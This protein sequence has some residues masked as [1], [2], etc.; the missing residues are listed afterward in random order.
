MN[1]CLKAGDRERPLDADTQERVSL[2]LTLLSVIPA[3]NPRRS[4]LQSLRNLAIWTG[5]PYGAAAAG[6][7]VRQAL[8]V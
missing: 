6:K 4:A 7:T 1:V 3:R 5:G 2:G 8:C